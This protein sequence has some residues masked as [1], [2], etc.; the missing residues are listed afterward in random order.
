MCLSPSVDFTWNS[1]ILLFALRSQ[2]WLFQGQGWLYAYVWSWILWWKWY[3][4]SSGEYKYMYRINCSLGS[5]P[6]M[7]SSALLDASLSSYTNFFSVYIM[8]ILLLTVL[9]KTVIYFC[10]LMVFSFSRATPCCSATVAIL[11]ICYGCSSNNIE[12]PFLQS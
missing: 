9:E 5:I 12:L 8:F 6:R 11:L 3:S 10:F 2:N 1:V 7:E 4:W